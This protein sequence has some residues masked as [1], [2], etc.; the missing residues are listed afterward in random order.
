MMLLNSNVSLYVR[1]IALLTSLFVAATA[2]SHG[3]ATAVSDKVRAIEFPDTA[4]YQT[5]TVDLHTH[6]VFSDGHVWP[7][8][9]VEEALRD[10]LDALAIT[11]H[12]EYQPHRADILHPDRNRAY[13]IAADA[14]KNSDLIV[15]RGSEI[16]RD[17][18]AGHI[19]AVFIDDANKL[20]KVDK[21]PADT[22]DVLAYYSAAKEWPAQKAVEAAQAQNAFI[23]WNHPYWTR[24]APDGIARMNEFHAANA[25]NG[26]LH[27][28]EVANGNT[29]SEEAFQLA[30]DYNLTLIGVSD[31][32]DLIDWDYKP[33]EGGHRPVTLVFTKAKTAAAIKEALFARRTVV[34]FRNLLIGREQ[35]LQPLLA[36]SLSASPLSYRATT[37]VAEVTLSN[38]SDADFDLRYTGDYTFM[39]N[40]DRIT[41]PAHGHIKLQIKPG[42]RSKNLTLPFVVEN[43]LTA[44]G[45]HARIEIEVAQ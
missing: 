22:S 9:R 44:P 43:T 34:W 19:N 39:N 24:Q 38:V 28:I 1:A 21:P 17:A 29:Y 15:I 33:H 7:K 6:S 20:I 14:A 36:A 8:I 30:L 31:V 11:E 5:L 2:Q 18:P 35:Q 10:Q 13:D 42:K 40:A 16:T 12:L 41:V 37:Q 27:G 45:E 32:H 23:F 4:D 25:R 26:L 3:G